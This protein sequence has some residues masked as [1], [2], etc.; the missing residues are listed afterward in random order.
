MANI[1]PNSVVVLHEAFARRMKQACD[2]N[3]DVPAMHDGRLTW[4][5]QKMSNE[6]VDVSLQTVLRWYY[7]AA[8]PRQKKMIAL[9]KVL[10]VSP[11]WLS[12]GREDQNKIETGGRR[13]STDG[14]VNA[15][16]GHFQMA[17]VPCAF[18]E[19]D[20][21]R[22]GLVHFYSIIQGRQHPIHVVSGSTDQKQ[23]HVVFQVPSNHSKAVVL[24]VLPID[25]KSI[26]VWHVPAETIEKE[27]ERDSDMK[28]LEAKLQGRS[29][30]LG[31]QKI[32][33]M[34]DLTKALTF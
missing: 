25:Q 19:K 24:V 33:P 21:P 8:L 18:P 5:R 34:A 10:G 16:A 12:L 9:A 7:G 26:E 29:L 30:G 23:T 4:L 3:G 17:G 20:D 14:A 11:S 27:G 32:S 2:A 15:L 13:I 28:T 31:R 6:S 22:A 1:T